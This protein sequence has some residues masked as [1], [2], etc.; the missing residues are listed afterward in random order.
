MRTSIQTST[1]EFR[2]IG[3]ISHPSDPAG[4]ESKLKER[5]IGSVLTLEMG[6]TGAT[7]KSSGSIIR[8]KE[9]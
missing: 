1:L 9:V 6:E 7:G 4:L 8:V 5:E 2:N 3:G